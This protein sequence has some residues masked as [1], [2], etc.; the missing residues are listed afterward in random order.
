MREG[1]ES[2]GEV[3]SDAMEGKGR[4]G[5]KVAEENDKRKVEENIIYVKRFVL[6]RCMERKGRGRGE[7]GREE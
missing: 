3:G 2:G 1:I 5:R 4:R 7:E 6:G